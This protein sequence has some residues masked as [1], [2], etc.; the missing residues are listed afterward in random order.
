VKRSAAA[1]RVDVRADDP[2][3]TPF[4]GLLLAG[5]LIRQTGLIERLDA[6]VDAVAPFKERRRG[7]SAGELLGDGAQAALDGGGPWRRP[8]RGR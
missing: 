2:S 1:P 8:R 3:L 7:A 5:E 6:A 4:A